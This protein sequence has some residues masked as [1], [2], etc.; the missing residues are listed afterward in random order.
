MVV[1]VNEDFTGSEEI[2]NANPFFRHVHQ[3]F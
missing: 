3:S 2:L 1:F